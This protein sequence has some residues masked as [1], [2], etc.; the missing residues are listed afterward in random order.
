MD[1]KLTMD[2]LKYVQNE[3]KLKGKK[4]GI[5]YILTILFG[6]IGIHLSYLEKS[7]LA[8][9]RGLLTIILITV[10]FPIK[11]LVETAQ[12]QGVT[13]ALQQYSSATFVLYII[14]AVTS[15]SWLIYDLINLPSMVKRAND[16]IE[17]RISVKVKE[18]RNVEGQL[19]DDAVS[20][21]IIEEIYNR[22][23]TSI[24]NEIET[25][26]KHID[27]QLSITRDKLMSKRDET[28]DLIDNID[29]NLKKL[30]SFSAEL[31][32]EIEKVKKT[33]FDEIKK[34]DD[35]LLI[36]YKLEKEALELSNKQTKVNLEPIDDFEV[37]LAGTVIDNEKSDET[38][39]ENNSIEIPSTTDSSADKVEEEQEA[40]L[41]EKEIIM[42]DEVE[43]DE[44]F[45]DNQLI[46]PTAENLIEPVEVT[47][48]I[49]ESHPEITESTKVNFEKNVIDTNQ[50]IGIKKGKYAVKGYIVG[51]MSA[52][53]QNIKFS[54]FDSDMN[55]A[56]AS[57]IHEKDPKK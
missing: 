37:Q 21:V 34:L 39:T 4:I 25:N 35:T 20:K 46:A 54:D 10:P 53:T 7:K 15:L 23:K 49:V 42:P 31:D 2:E 43:V 14:I 45:S 16:K 11:A 33:S 51:Q 36:Q 40:E 48:Q 13:L 30:A 57:N 1:T 3:I 6:F 52:I 12:T 32:D 24:D 18:A 27:E 19:R 22:V 44:D 56:I 8:I 41:E 55:I 28:I 17:S 50:A 9:I 26:S 29:A 38:S 47:E 5:A